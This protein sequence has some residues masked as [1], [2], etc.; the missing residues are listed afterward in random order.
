MKLGGQD[1][2]VVG[3]GCNGIIPDDLTIGLWSNDTQPVLGETVIRP[4]ALKQLVHLSLQLGIGCDFPVTKGSHFI[5]F[6]ILTL[7]PRT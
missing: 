4:S 2:N 5:A 7:Q 6:D 3:N 1:K